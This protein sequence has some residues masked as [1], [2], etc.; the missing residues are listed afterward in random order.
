MKRSPGA[1]GE[2]IASA[3]TRTHNSLAT[4]GYA[5][6]SRLLGVPVR[7]ES[8]FGD[9]AELDVISG[10]GVQQRN[11]VDRVHLRN[12][13]REEF[14]RNIANRKLSLALLKANRRRRGEDFDQD[15]PVLVYE[16]S[17]G[18]ARTGWYR[19]HCVL[20]GKQQSLVRKQNGMTVWRTNENVKPA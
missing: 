14:V 3:A 5:P 16:K 6:Y 18:K 11:R 9:D 4:H 19:G 1:T 7:L 2:E 8:I 17:L 10:E 12:I 20:K 13:A 15:A